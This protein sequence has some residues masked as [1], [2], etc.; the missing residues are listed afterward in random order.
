MQSKTSHLIIAK[1]NVKSGLVA[2]A[3]TLCLTGLYLCIT[4]ITNSGSIDIKAAFL[5]GK[6]TTESL[7]LLVIFLAL[8]VVLAARTISIREKHVEITHG[9]L[10]INAANMDEAEWEHLG[11]CIRAHEEQHKALQKGSS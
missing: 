4:G 2:L 6:I 5:E 11:Q 10:K 9:D 8:P 1:L 3:F 7:G